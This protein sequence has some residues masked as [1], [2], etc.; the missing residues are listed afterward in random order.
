MQVFGKFLPVE[1]PLIQYRNPEPKCFSIVV[2]DKREKEVPA[3]G[4]EPPTPGCPI[5]GHDTIPIVVQ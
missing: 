5:A 3:R 1:L 2:C 4:F